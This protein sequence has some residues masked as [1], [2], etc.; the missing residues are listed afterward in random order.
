[1]TTYNEYQ[2]V[3]FLFSV[4]FCVAIAIMRNNNDYFAIVL[5]MTNVLFL[6]VILILVTTFAIAKM[7]LG[8]ETW[9]G[10]LKNYLK[11]FFKKLFI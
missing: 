6:P 5:K 11:P 3:W 1:M 8:R 7:Y 2:L 4:I 9:D 10:F